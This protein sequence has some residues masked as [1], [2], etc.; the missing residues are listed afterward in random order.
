[1]S[2]STDTAL[3]IWD[4]G[5]G[6]CVHTL[7]G[8][9][10]VI[11][12]LALRDN[13]LISGSNDTIVRIWDLSSGQCLHVLQNHPSYITGVQL[14]VVT[15]KLTVEPPAKGRRGHTFAHTD[16]VPVATF[17]LSDH[18]HRICGAYARYMH[19]YSCKIL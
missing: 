6:A 5:S 3:R 7:N 17:K 13:L 2:G 19:V 4:T 16:Y 18:M 8:H 9:T 10:G 14:S 1:V 15:E 11:L 12:C